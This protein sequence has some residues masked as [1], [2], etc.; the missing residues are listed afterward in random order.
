MEAPGASLYRAVVAIANYIA[1]YRPDL[2]YA[3]KEL[4]RRMSDPSEACLTKLK[5]LGRYLK[6]QPRAV[7]MFLWQEAQISLDVFTDA[8][9]AGCKASRKSTSGGAILLG[10]HCV[11]SWSKTQN[12]IAQSSAESELIAIVKAAS[13]ALDMMS[14]A[15]DLGM[16]VRTRLHVDASAALGILEQR[17]RQSQASGCGDALAPR[18]TTS[19]SHLICQGTR[20]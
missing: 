10:S 12:T 15:E 11:R 1:Q 4:C 7:S 13:E 9:W 14:L 8:N 3:F 16:Q 6:G 19:P 2:Q 5:R 18:A 17:G 20:N